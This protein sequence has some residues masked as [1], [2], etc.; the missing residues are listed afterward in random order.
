[1][2]GFHIFS[3]PKCQRWSVCLSVCVRVRL[4]S[5]STDRRVLFISR[6][7][8]FTNRWWA[9]DGYVYSVSKYRILLSRASIAR[10][11]HAKNCSLL[12]LAKSIPCCRARTWRVWSQIGSVLCPAAKRFQCAVLS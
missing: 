4:D 11:C 6:I 3:T 12:F 10:G 5:A 1:L 8:G 9:R 7:Q 2:T